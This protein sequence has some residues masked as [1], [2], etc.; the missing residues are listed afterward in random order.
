MYTTSDVVTVSKRE[1]EN[2]ASYWKM[3]TLETNAYRGEKN[4]IQ[5]SGG[6]C[7][8]TV[9]QVEEGVDVPLSKER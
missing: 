1:L 2:E 4:M 5:R 9:K 8:T 3:K 6:C 7:N